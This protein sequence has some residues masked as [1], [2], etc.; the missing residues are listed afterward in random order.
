MFLIKN[1]LFTKITA[2]ILLIAKPKTLLHSLFAIWFPVSQMKNRN[3]FHVDNEKWPKTTHSE[4]RNSIKKYSQNYVK[5]CEKMFFRF[6]LQRKC[7]RFLSCI[8][9]FLLLHLSKHFRKLIVYWFVSTPKI[10]LALNLMNIQILNKG[11]KWFTISDFIVILLLQFLW[12]FPK[13]KYK[14]LYSVKEM[15]TNAALSFK[16]VT[17]TFSTFFES[18]WQCLIQSWNK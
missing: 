8:L 1:C 4:Q 6:C 15:I 10:S 16:F 9:V 17:F 7:S 12:I 18:Q 14:K 2:V 13:G 3:S 11:F 5:C